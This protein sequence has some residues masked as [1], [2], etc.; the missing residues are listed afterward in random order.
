MRSAPPTPTQTPTT[1]LLLELNPDEDCGDE[2]VE[3]DGEEVDCVTKEVWVTTIV[4]PLS[5]DANVVVSNE[6]EVVG[7]DV[8]VSSVDRCVVV[9]GANDVDDGVTEENEK[10]EVLLLSV[11][12]NENELDEEVDRLENE[13]SDE[14]LDDG[15]DVENASDV[16]VSE[17]VLTETLLNI[18]EADTEEEVVSEFPSAL[19]TNRMSEVAVSSDSS[20]S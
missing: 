3:E 20:A 5:T 13:N 12:E 6:L 1:I 14:K 9:E 2:V 11:W 18:G 4:F 10:L 7:V 16:D 15:K 17:K 8:G 19:A